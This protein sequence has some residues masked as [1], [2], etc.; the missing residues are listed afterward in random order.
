MIDND[1]L[2]GK[3]NDISILQENLT[4]LA[5]HADKIKNA[6]IS[7]KLVN[8][9]LPN[10]ETIGIKIS[11]EWRQMIYDDCI[12]KADRILGHLLARD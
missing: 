9:E 6:L 11:P 3:I 2:L 10:D 7:I 4:N 12:I 1:I 5:A 8:G